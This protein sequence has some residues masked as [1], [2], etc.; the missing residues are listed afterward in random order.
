MLFKI[1]QLK[2]RTGVEANLFAIPLSAYYALYFVA[3]LFFRIII[4]LVFPIKW[5]KIHQFR[6]IGRNDSFN[7]NTP[8]FRGCS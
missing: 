1:D 3:L 6:M 2:Y 4:R 8:K 5:K 7:E